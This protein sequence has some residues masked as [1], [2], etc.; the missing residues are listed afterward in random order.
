MAI[1][2]LSHNKEIKKGLYLVPTPIGNLGDITFRAIEILKKSDLIL[3]EDTRVSG[4]LFEK[5]E[6]KSK[7]LSNHK[8]NEKKNLSK[9]ISGLKNGQIISLIS[10]AGTPGISD[11][12]AIL[13]KECVREKIDITPLP[14]ASAVNTSISASGFSE[15]Y[16]FYGFFPTKLKNIQDDL[17]SLS[18]LDASIVF[19]ISSKKLNKAIPIIKQNFSGREIIICREMTKFY[20]EYLRYKVEDL[21]IFD[22]TL[23][24]ELT[25]VISE[26]KRV[27]KGSLF[28]SESDKKDIKKMIKKLS[29]KEITNLIARN[30]NIP[31][32]EIYNYCV[33]VKNEN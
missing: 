24:G 28:L 14:G 30:N 22:E 12:G 29:I 16:F 9:V 15:K 25:I 2:P 11:P 5:F 31:K 18:S 26:K 1:N 10:D 4:K 21:K 33:K 6:I 19:F 27:K 13:V 17:R 20:E 7:L 32:K 8:F 23:K 3:C